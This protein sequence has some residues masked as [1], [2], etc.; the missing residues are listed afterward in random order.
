[1]N[2]H[3]LPRKLDFVQDLLSQHSLSI[4]GIT[5]TDLKEERHSDAVVTIPDF[6][7]ERRDADQQL[8]KGVIVYI[9]HAITNCVKRRLDLE[10]P[11]VECIWLEIRPC[12]QKPLLAGFLYRNPRNK[13]DY[14]HKWCD[15]FMQMMIKVNSCRL[16]LILLGDFNVDLLKDQTEWISTTNTLGLNQLIKSPTR[17]EKRGSLITQTLIDHIYTNNSVIIHDSFASDICM[18]DHK[19]VICTWSCKLPQRETKG[20]KYLWYRCAKKF[21]ED[22][23]CADL[24]LANLE[25]VVLD[26]STADNAATAWSASFLSIVDKH[27]PLRKK[28]IRNQPTPNWLTQE[29]KEAMRVRDTLKKNKQFEAYKKQRNKVTDMLRK[30]KC[31]YYEKTVKDSKNM[32]QVW[33]AVNVLSNKKQSQANKSNFKFSPND[34]NTYFISVTDTILGSST[35]TSYCLDEATKSHIKDFCSSKLTNLDS[36]TIPFLT[37][38]EVIRLVSNISN[39]KTMGTDTLNARII[40]C[41]LPCIAV[42]LTHL[43]NRCIEEHIFPSVFKEAMVIPLPKCKKPSTLDDFR[44]ISIL[45]ILSKPLEKHVHNNLLY[46]LESKQLFHEYQSGFRP[47]HSCHTALIRLCNSWLEKIN[48]HEMIGT[49]FL[50]LRKAFNCVSHRIL[51]EKLHMYCQSDD[52]VRFFTSY[53]SSRTQ[54]T[55]I[56]GSLSSSGELK[57]G[58]PQGSILGPLLFCIFI[59]D[60]PLFLRH[61]AE[62]TLDLF[63]DDSTLSTSSKN[64]LTI[65]Q[66]LQNSIDDVS[67]WCNSN[68]MALNHLKSKSMVITTRQKHQLQPLSLQLSI[69]S[70]TIQQVKVHRVLGCIIDETMSFHPHIDSVLKTVS[71]N[72]YLMSRLWHYVS[73]EALLAFFYGHCLSHINYASTVWCNADENYLNKLNRLHKRAIKIMNRTPNT[74][75]TEKYKLLKI[76]TLKDQFKYNTC[77]M[78]FK[79]SHELVPTYLHKLLPRQNPRTLDYAKPSR[80]YRL[81]ITQAGFIYSSVSIWNALPRHCKSCRTFGTFRKAVHLH[82]LT[83]LSI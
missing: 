59:N 35:N 81:D 5:E 9:H 38:R 56:N 47:N 54:R 10:T 50:D 22:D 24:C 62:V 82:Y 40:K 23:F 49:L 69:G 11:S 45:P 6:T 7:F 55:L 70:N 57:C 32:S 25:H 41:A 48:D 76:L 4:L 15:D 78:V 21:N 46:Y 34:V 71:R 83:H 39:K 73:T 77:K 66:T 27:F 18:S 19:P 75:T 17:I 30:S 13:I 28:R 65:Q 79:Q 29:I 8:H 12:S 63:A 3:S 1:M 16:N 72:L 67:R 74:S 26:S 80:T 60:L 36:F 14:D 61:K 64:I 2:I 31:A 33:H 51:L 68:K 37:V 52:A 42:S 43:Y 53:L 58:V 20:H 44:P